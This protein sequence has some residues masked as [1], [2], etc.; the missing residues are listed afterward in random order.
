M[1]YYPPL[2]PPAP[3]HGLNWRGF[4]DPCK[5][6]PPGFAT[7]QTLP[8]AVEQAPSKNNNTT[9]GV[10]VVPLALL[11][12]GHAPKRVVPII[13][14]AAVAPPKDHARLVAREGLRGVEAQVAW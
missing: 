14:L 12:D 1:I 5:I 13:A 2:Q 3:T 7:E 10:G 9:L 8:G 11:A 4:I 6:K